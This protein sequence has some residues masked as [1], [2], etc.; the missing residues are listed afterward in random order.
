[1]THN[2]T[3]ITTAELLCTLSRSDCG[4]DST[5]KRSCAT[6]S[7]VSTEMG[8]HLQVTVSRGTLA[9]VELSIISHV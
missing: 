1:M 4:K 9:A 2:T 5:G 7:L 8:D 3:R 6:S